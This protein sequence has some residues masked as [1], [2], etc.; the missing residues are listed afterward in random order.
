MNPRKHFGRVYDAQVT[1]IY[2]YIRLKVNSRE[3]A[4]DITAQVFE[5][6]WLVYREGLDPDSHR[7]EVKSLK[8]LLYQLARHAIA[9]YYRTESRREVVYLG[10]RDLPEE[11]S[12]LP[13][14]VAQQEEMN[15]V[16]RA[17]SKIN[18]DYQDLIIQHYLNGL[19]LEEIAGH[20]GRSI[21]A[22][23]TALHRARE[24]L[25]QELGDNQE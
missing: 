10:D 20:S 25:K 22:V 5:R 6:G 23:K 14:K 24:A 15:A 17:L 2:R 9:D 4:E 19:S 7:P 12:N 3:V 1:K 18:P 13:E 11:N 16:L 8:A 21:G